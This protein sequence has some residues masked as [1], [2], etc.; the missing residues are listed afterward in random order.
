MYTASSRVKVYCFIVKGKIQFTNPEINTDT[1][2]NLIR[3]TIPNP[4]KQLKPG[5]QAYVVIKSSETKFLSLPSDAV[6]RGARGASVWV[7]TSGNKFKYKM[8]ETG[9][10]SNDRIEIKSCLAIG[11]VVVISGNY[12]L[13]SEYIFT[14][15]SNPKQAMKM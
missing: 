1:R 12:L 6:I 15:G 5:M 13:N 11:G 3:V 7:Q 9:M 4:G 10:E 14:I 8:V 2:I